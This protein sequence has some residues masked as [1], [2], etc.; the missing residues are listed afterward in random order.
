M[1]TLRIFVTVVC[2][3]AQP[4]LAACTA[5]DAASSDAPSDAD[6]IHIED[7]WI[8]PPA[9]A[10]GNGALYMTLR[11]AGDTADRMLTVETAIAQAVELHETQNDNG[12]MRMQPLEGGVE[13]PARQDVE[14]GPGG[15]H[16]MLLNVTDP[17]AVG[18]AV[19]VTLTFE[20]AGHVTLAIPVA[21]AAP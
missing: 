4:A 7:M 14:F 2:L 15:K 20:K 6:G 1:N 11:N 16:V 13:V 10:G 21:E 5:P 9:V 3:V 17:L 19:T 12:V 8:R 18:Q